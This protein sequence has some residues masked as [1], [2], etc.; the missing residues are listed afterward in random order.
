MSTENNISRKGVIVIPRISLWAGR[1]HVRREELGVELP[2]GVVTPG[3]KRI[4][5][6]SLLKPMETIKSKV[7][8]ALEKVSVSYGKGVYLVDEDLLPE[9]IRTMDGLK[10]QFVQEVQ[11]FRANYRD[12]MA[13]WLPTIDSPEW[14][15]Y[16][17]RAALSPTEAASKYAFMYSVLR[18][19]TPEEAEEANNEVLRGLRGRMWEELAEIATGALRYMEDKE[20]MTQK[21]KSPFRRI[22]EKAMAVAFVDPLGR[23]L[24]GYIQCKLDDLPKTGKLEGQ[25]FQ[26]LQVLASSLADPQRAIGLAK[27]FKMSSPSSSEGLNEDIEEEPATPDPVERDSH[28]DQPSQDGWGFF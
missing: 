1:R 23:S 28:Q 2:K 9:V 18:I 15:T 5:P 4:A 25:A 12:E 14:R 24:A 22:A 11:A 26:D 3:S 10:A 16:V 21:G 20:T 7:V 8:T 13:A 27:T 17:E 19:N 6:P